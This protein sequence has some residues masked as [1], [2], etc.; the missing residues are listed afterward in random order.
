MYEKEETNRRLQDKLKETR[1]I[2]LF[3]QYP[4]SNNLTES[5]LECSSSLPLKEVTQMAYKVSNWFIAAFSQLYKSFKNDNHWSVS[6][7]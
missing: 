3:V 1:K 7:A 2:K 4:D 5:K 6:A